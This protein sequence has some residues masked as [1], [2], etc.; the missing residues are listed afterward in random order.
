MAE[1]E[2]REE[3]PQ[4]VAEQPQVQ[5]RQ[6]DMPEL[7]ETFADSINSTFFDGQSLRINFGVTRFDQS[8][9]AVATSATRYP[10][11]RLVLTPGA[12]IDLM[13]QMQQ[14]LTKLIQSGVLKAS[15][16]PTP[17]KQAN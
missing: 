16:A 8:S 12:A 3:Q 7:K 15:S 1:T 13:N 2:P 4:K 6:V 10:A 9:A 5:L 11:C 17:P 14:L